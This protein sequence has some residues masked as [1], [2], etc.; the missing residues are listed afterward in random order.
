M[1]GSAV[2]PTGGVVAGARITNTNPPTNQV[3]TV[4]TNDAGVFSVPALRPG[5]GSEFHTPG[6]GEI[7]AK[8]LVCVMV[9]PATRH[10][11]SYPNIRSYF[12]RQ[13]LSLS[14]LTY[15]DASAGYIPDRR[16]ESMTNER[17]A[18]A[19][20]A[21]LASMIAVSAQVRRAPPQAAPPAARSGD[22]RDKIETIRARLPAGVPPVNRIA[23]V[24]MKDPATGLT[25]GVI[26]IFPPGPDGA[27]YANWPV[28]AVS[29]KEDGDGGCGDDRFKFEPLPPDETRLPDLEVE[30]IPLNPA[31]VKGLKD[32]MNQKSNICGAAIGVYSG[33]RLTPGNFRLL[34]RGSSSG[35][36]TGLPGLSGAV[37]AVAGPAQAQVM[38]E[39]ERAQVALQRRA[40]SVCEQWARI[41]GARGRGSQAIPA[42]DGLREVCSAKLQGRQPQVDQ[43]RKQAI[44]DTT[45]ADWERLTAGRQRSAEWQSLPAMQE[46]AAG[47]SRPQQILKNAK[48]TGKPGENRPPNYVIDFSSGCCCEGAWSCGWE[49]MFGTCTSECD[50]KKRICEAHN[51]GW[52]AAL[53]RVVDPDKLIK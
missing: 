41:Q 48:C 30:D 7:V 51:G 35:F 38:V 31:L 53:G 34:P 40:Q 37:P 22:Y 20:V 27:S 12:N 5:S 19:F 39:H 32:F 17:L 4:E 9:R 11:L 33:G 43:S 49:A 18:K 52:S 47:C 16:K 26:T 44:V 29:K 3:R 23:K 1:T 14:C 21:L 6:G 45:C 46:L 13:S 2:D 25:L 15:T 42:F 50:F 10:Q 36:D 8:P 24:R 28:F